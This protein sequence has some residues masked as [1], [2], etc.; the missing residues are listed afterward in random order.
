MTA[1]NSV[2]DKTDPCLTLRFTL[3]GLESML[4]TVTTLQE[5]VYQFLITRQH[6]PLT[7]NLKM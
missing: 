7:P 6:L 2:G 4:L 1:M 5:S 3:K